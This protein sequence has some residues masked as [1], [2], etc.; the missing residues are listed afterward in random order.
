MTAAKERLEMERYVKA[1]LP[2]SKIMLMRS[3]QIT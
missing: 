1:E 3:L 2:L